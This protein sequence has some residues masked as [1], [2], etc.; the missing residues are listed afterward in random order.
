MSCIAILSADGFSLS[1]LFSLFFFSV[2]RHSKCLLCFQRLFRYVVSLKTFRSLLGTD[3]FFSKG[4]LHF[5]REH[6]QAINP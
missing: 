6:K 1:L 3:V 4:S 5:F 2:S